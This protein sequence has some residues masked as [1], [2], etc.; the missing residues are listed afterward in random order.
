MSIAKFA[1]EKGKKVLVLEQESRAGEGVSSRNSGVIHAGMYYPKESLKTKFCLEGN[2]MLYEYAEFKNISHK[3]TGKFIVASHKNELANLEKIFLQGKSNGVSLKKCSLD[4]IKKKEPELDIAGALFSPETG[5][6][7]VPE[8]I[9]SLEGDIQHHDGVVSF[10]T[11]FLSA[12]RNGN[13]FSIKC[14]DGNKFEIETSILINSAGLG[15]EN[16]SSNISAL[17]K[18]FTHKIYFAKGHYFKYSGINPFDSLIYPLPSE[19]SQG[20]HVGFDISRQ[21]RFGPDIA[22]VDEIDYVFD[23][24]LKE[25]FVCSIHNYWPGMEPERLHPDYCGIRP[26]IQ[27]PSEKMQDFSIQ[28]PKDHKIEGF[29]NLQGIESPGITSSLAIGKYVSSMI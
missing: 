6:I 7:D 18:E 3:K 4:E 19:S 20:L 24:S 26:K 27:K 13:A 9:T 14:S 11:N 5:I 25:K 12:K 1:A 10:N 15:S 8:L 22:W 23:E 17:K 28:F 21:L 2:R 29:I 16:V